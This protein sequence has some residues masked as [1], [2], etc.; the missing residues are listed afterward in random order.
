ME[1]KEKENKRNINEHV[2]KYNYKT[3]ST[4]KAIVNGEYS[5]KY[6]D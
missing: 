1:L 3:I 4:C 6:T 5:M 2:T